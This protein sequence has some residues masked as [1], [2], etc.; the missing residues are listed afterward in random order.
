MENVQ[1][2]FI[3]QA[4]I[5]ESIERINRD[6]LNI[7]GDP[8]TTAMLH[9]ERAQLEAQERAFKGILSPVVEPVIEK[10]PDLYRIG[11]Q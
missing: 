10:Y 3:S 9:S 1:N 2:S 5:D 8:T 11:E 4:E 6:I 7:D